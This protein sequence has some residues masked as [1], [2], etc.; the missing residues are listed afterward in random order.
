MPRIPQLIEGGHQVTRELAIP[1]SYEGRHVAWQ[2]FDR[3]VDNAVIAEIKAMEKLSRRLSPTH[4][5]P[6]R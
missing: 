4:N 6:A 1:V 3:V 2:R 5:V